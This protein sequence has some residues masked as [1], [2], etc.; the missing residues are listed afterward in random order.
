MLVRTNRHRRL[1]PKW[2]RKCWTPWYDLARE[3]I[4]HV[5]VT[6]EWDFAREV[7]NRIVFRMRGKSSN[8]TPTKEFFANPQHERTKLSQPDMPVNLSPH[9]EERG[10]WRALEP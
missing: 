2:S 9:G 1:T 7:A 8:R 3:G 6:N 5:V 4:D 10:L